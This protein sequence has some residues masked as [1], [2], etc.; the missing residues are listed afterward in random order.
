MSESNL[1]RNARSSNRSNS[2]GG[3]RAAGGGRRDEPDDALGQVRDTA[4]EVA[5]RVISG[6]REIKEQVM[7]K[8]AQLGRAVA[9]G[10]KEEAEKFFDEQ[11]G[12]LGDKVDRFGKM[13]NQAAH[14]LRAVK[15]D[16]VAEAVDSAAGRFRDASSYIE[17]R[18]LGDILSDAEDVARRHPGL[19]LG[20][21]FLTGLLAARF[22]KASA[23]REES[24][25]GGRSRSRAS[26]G[27]RGR[28]SDRRAARSR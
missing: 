22:V 13:I 1:R 6:T 8:A 9:D 24:V 20:G 23:S 3:S 15:A 28:G 7:E 5:G 26:R 4:V 12:K 10:V 11:K 16:P 25:G 21:L 17:D 19:M 2:K 14:A 27:A 18:S